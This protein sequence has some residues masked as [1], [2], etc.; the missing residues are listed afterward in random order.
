VPSL[1]SSRGQRILRVGAGLRL[2]KAVGRSL[3]GGELRQILFLLRVR[4]E[5]KI[6]RVP[7]P[8]CAPCV[9]AK[10][11]DGKFFGKNSM[12]ILSRPAPPYS[13]GTPPPSNRLAPFFTNWG[14]SPGL[15]VLQILIKGKLPLGQILR[16]LPD[17]FLIVGEIR[18]RKHIAGLRDSRRK[19]PPF[20]AGLVRVAVAI[21]SSS[22]KSL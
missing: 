20:A 10:R 15:F 21:W 13:S 11:V 14:I 2:G 7:I 19:L 16:R 3:A 17:Q 1:F 22:R 18:R 9:T 4:A 5:I 12:E 8:A 6:G